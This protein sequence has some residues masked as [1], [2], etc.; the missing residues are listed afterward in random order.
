MV[1]IPSNKLTSLYKLKAVKNNLEQILERPPTEDEIYYHSDDK[2][3]KKES[4]SD[5]LEMERDRYKS[6][7]DKVGE[8]NDRDEV[9]DM[10]ESYDDDFETDNWTKQHDLKII[11]KMAFKRL[12][13]ME[14]EV[15][16]LSFGIEDG[17][18]LNNKQVAEIIGKSSE[19][20]RMTKKKV[21]KK[22]YHIVGKSNILE[23]KTYL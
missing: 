1:R 12:T 5:L 17:Q 15:I 22:L 6:T 20:V 14:R 19:H 21:F 11:F 2:S 7:N 13:K 8:N 10:I 4:I 16:K 18:E 3:I 9:G 23:T